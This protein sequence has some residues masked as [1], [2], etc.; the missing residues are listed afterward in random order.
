MFLLGPEVERT[1]QVKVIDY[2]VR[3]MCGTNPID[4]RLRKIAGTPG[5]M[6]PEQWRGAP[7]PK[8]DV[9]S[10]GCLLYELVTGELPFSGGMLQVM[11]AHMQE[12]PARPSDRFPL[13]ADLEH[14][15]L[16][17]M[18]KDPVM[19]PTMLELASA[20]TRMSRR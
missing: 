10:L 20:L 4:D 17:A 14:V 1:P 18:E 9:Y 13:R 16:R 19:R 2:G 3:W 6:S 8:S 5:Y 11:R 12:A 15:I 7:T